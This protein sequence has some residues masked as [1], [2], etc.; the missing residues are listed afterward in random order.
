MTTSCKFRQQGASLVDNLKIA[1]V[2]RMHSCEQTALAAEIKICINEY[3]KELEASPIRSLADVIAF[4]K[5]NSDLVSIMNSGS[6][7]LCN[8]LHSYIRFT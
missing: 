3:L 6:L 8:V 4:N 5:K 2:G 7:V 1:N